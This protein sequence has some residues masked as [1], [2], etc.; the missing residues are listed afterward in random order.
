MKIWPKSQGF[1]ECAIRARIRQVK[2]GRHFRQQ[3][4]HRGDEEHLKELGQ[5]DR[6]ELQL[7]N[8]LLLK[9]FKA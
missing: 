2:E 7:A 9:D 3:G 8:K 6:Y 1:N 4:G 5:C